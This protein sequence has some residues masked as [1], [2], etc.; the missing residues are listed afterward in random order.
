LKLVLFVSAKSFACSIIDVLI[1][2]IIATSFSVSH[3]YIELLNNHMRLK[4]GD[5]VCKYI[6][7]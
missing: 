1:S 6:T 7:T 5:L 2:D 3:L 4:E